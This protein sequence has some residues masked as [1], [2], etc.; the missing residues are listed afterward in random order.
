MDELPD[1]LGRDD[2][3]VFDDA[4]AVAPTVD[5]REVDVLVLVAQAR[6]L[7]AHLDAEP[8][9]VPADGLSEKQARPAQGSQVRRVASVE[10][11]PVEQGAMS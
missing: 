1:D 9:A 5:E 8:E 10:T 11:A 6:A 2:E 3:L 7:M 4:S